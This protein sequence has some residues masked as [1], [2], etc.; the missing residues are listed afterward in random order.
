[1]NENIKTWTTAL[2]DP[3][4][5]QTQGKLCRIDPDTGTPSYCCL[6]VAASIAPDVE[7][8]EP[9]DDPD[10]DFY[11]CHGHSDTV[12]FNGVEDLLPAEVAG[13]LGVE[14]DGEMIDLV[15][16]WGDRLLALRTQGGDPAVQPVTRGPERM[17]S[18]T[19]ATLNDHGLTFPQIADLIDYFHVLPAH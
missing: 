13:W 15:P 11:D 17:G 2:R 6:G 3:S 18:Q 19:L 9:C 1:M 5:R 12:L 7:M 4:L 8:S 10:C 16:D 14:P